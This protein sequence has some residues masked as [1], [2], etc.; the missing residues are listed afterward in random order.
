MHLVL[1]G[2]SKVRFVLAGFGWSSG[3]LVQA[4]SGLFLLQGLCRVTQFGEVL[5]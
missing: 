3:L 1:L 5:G 2:V 4:L